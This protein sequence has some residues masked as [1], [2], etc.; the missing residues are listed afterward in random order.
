MAV[1]FIAGA[2][3]CGKINITKNAGDIVIAADAGIR[4]LENSGIS[5]DYI[6]GDFDSLGTLPEGDNV[7]RLKPEKDI[8]DMHAAVDIGIEKGCTDFVIYGATGGRLAHTLA[9]IQLAASLAQKGFGVV[10]KDEKTEIRAICNSSAGFSADYSGYI[11]VFAHSDVCTGVTIKGLKYELENSEMKNSFAL[12][13]SNEF[14]GKES[15]V[16]VKNGTLIIVYNTLK[17]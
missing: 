6:I 5:P 17:C 11:S 1:C 8:T 7:V 2:G 12:G 13:V 10:I 15:T 16:E 4:Y 14:F 9:N 3:D